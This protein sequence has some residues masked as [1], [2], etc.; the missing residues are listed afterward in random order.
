MPLSARG[1]SV[2]FGGL[3]ALQGVG[4]EVEARR[5]VGLIGPNGAGKTTLFAV[6]SGHLRPQEGQVLLDGAPIL[7]LPPEARA[8]L[9]VVRTFQIPRPLPRLTVYE[10]A[11]VFARFAGRSPDPEGSARRALEALGLLELAET[12]AEWLNVAQLKRLELARA[13]AARPLYLLLDEVFA[14]LNPLEKAELAERVEALAREEGLGLLIVEH[15]LKTVFRLA[16]WVYV[17]S[18][19]ALIAQGPPEA[20]A[21]D[22]KVVE[23]Y[24]GGVV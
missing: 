3:L 4:L 16:E 24:T 9:G 17:L 22:P 20:V 6:L 21:G 14:G 15:D 23:I 2:R 10:N 11:L 5:R 13:L 12:P 1:V 19:G 18:F 7:H 8:R